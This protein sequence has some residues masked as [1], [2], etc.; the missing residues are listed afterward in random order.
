M[1]DDVMQSGCSCDGCLTVPIP[2]VEGPFVVEFVVG[3]QQSFFGIEC[4]FRKCN[5]AC[6]VANRPGDTLN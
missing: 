3:Q 2:K 4:P 5:G 6:S 1:N